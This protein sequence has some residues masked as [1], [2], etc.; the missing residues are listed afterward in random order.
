MSATDRMVVQL[1]V[2]E[3]RALIADAVAEVAQAEPQREWMTLG[4][5]CEYLR[6]SRSSANKLRERGLPCS[7]IG[8][9]PRFSRARV[10]A[11]MLGS[12]AEAAE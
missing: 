7:M 12:A 8:D 4:E 11:W 1:T 2:A 9:S 5:L 3:L 10:A 6:C